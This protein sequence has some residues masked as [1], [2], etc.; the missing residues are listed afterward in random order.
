MGGKS[1]KQTVGYK[2]YLGMHQVLCHGPIDAVTKATVDDRTAW[3]GISTGGSIN[4]NSPSLFGGNGREGG[5]SGTIDIMMGG[6]AQGQNSYLVGQLGNSIPGY[7]GVVSVVFRQCYLGNNPYLK[8][9]RFRGQRIYKR[10]NDLAQWYPSRAAIGTL[11]G[12]H[13][14]FITLDVSGSMDQLVAPGVTRLQNAKA[15]LIGVMDY[16]AT[17]AANTASVDVMVVA[18]GGT[19]TSILRRNVGPSD[20]TAI[21]SFINSRATVGN[22]DF[23][24]GVADVASFYAGAPSDARRTVVFVTDGEP[25]MGGSPS[26]IT[27]ATQAQATLFSTPGISSYAFN[28]DL[29]N[30]TYTAYMDNTPIDGVPVVVGADNTSLLSSI[31]SV[32]GNALDMNPAHMIRECL[33]DPDWGMGYL[34]SDV[35]D[36][37]FQSCAN[38]LVIEGLGM[39]LLWDKSIIID[40]FIQEVVKHIDAAL[41]VSRS[42]GKFCLKLIRADYDENTLLHLDESN[43]ARIEDPSRASFGELTNSVTINYWDAITGKDASLTVTDTAL[44]QV[45]GAVIN[46]PVQ[47]PGFTNARNATI[48]GQRDLR[49]LSSPLLACTV[50]ANTEAKDLNVGDV[51]KLSWKKW[52]IANVVMRITGI[53][54]GNGKSNQVKLACVQDTFSTITS[55]VVSTPPSNEWQDP[56]GPPG[57][58]AQQIAQEAP[59]YEIVQ[60]LGQSDADNKL[61]THPEIGFVLAAASRAPSAINARMWSDNGDGYE[62]TGALDFSPVATLEAAITQTQTEFVVTDAN[63]L[64]EV[65][66]GTHF[67]VGDELMR[68]DAIDAGTNTLTVGRGVLDTVPQPHAAGEDVIFWDQYAGFDPTEYVEG[69]EVNIKITPVSGAGVYP[70]E[71]AIPMLVELDHRASR[72]YAPG[73]LRINDES[74]QNN[75]YDGELTIT[76]AHRNRLQQTSGTLLD[77]TAGNIGPEAGTLYRVQGYIDGVLDHT[78]DDI[79]GTSATW[80]PSANGIAKVEVHAKRDEVYSWQGPWHE[81]SYGGDLRLTEDGD[82]RVT[83]DGDI[84]ILED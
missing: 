41:Y 61:L 18:W 80:T 11:T 9:W 76:W 2:Y 65:I 22:T 35:E 56:S 79:N 54:I 26:A 42:T 5:V 6:P 62:D 73:D 32:L 39:S 63:D 83:E 37:T 81:F 19:R 23:R 20:I 34:D 17:Y 44:V 74:Y 43:I 50:Y 60:L 30:T 10:Q 45:Q 70:L 77:H 64:S 66:L 57:G 48:A 29:P 53:A 55:L 52:Q 67:Q 7:R 58:A 75:A 14:I 27:I 25:D 36:S 21:K 3:I 1:K 16:I 47:Y 8:P 59:Y 46:V 31:Q 68:I 84:R 15:S 28:I 40:A 49:T 13:A 78:E 82:I 12:N 51:F 72:P 69:E 33:T 24:Q 71:D 38:R 4:V